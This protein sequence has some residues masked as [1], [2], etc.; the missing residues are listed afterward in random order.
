[1]AGDEA[2]RAFDQIAPVYD[3]TREPLGPASIEALVRV[4]QKEGCVSL[5]EVGVGTGRIAGPLGSHGFEITG[6]DASREMLAR[7]QEKRVGRLVRGS[8]YALPLRDETVDGALF[9]HVLHVLAE[10]KRALAEASRVSRRRVFALVMERHRKTADGEAVPQESDEHRLLRDLL[11]AKGYPLPR[12]QRPWQKDHELI[13]SVPPKE[14][15]VISDQVVTETLEDRLRRIEKRA[16]RL[17]LHVPRE[18]LDAAIREVRARSTPGT[19]APSV[20]YRRK[21][22]VASWEPATLRGLAH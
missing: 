3:Q 6:V 12:R 16:D 7:A 4:L 17:T 13:A 5:L 10:P 2:V 14:L 18:V 22:S 9:A 19:Q 8:A 1:M 15:A 11:E 21:L 20:T